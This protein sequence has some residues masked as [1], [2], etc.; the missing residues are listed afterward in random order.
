[1]WKRELKGERI[2]SLADDDALISGFLFGGFLILL[3]KLD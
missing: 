2:N 3:T 1:M